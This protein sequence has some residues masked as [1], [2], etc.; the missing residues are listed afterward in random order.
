V[1]LAYIYIDETEKNNF[2]NDYYGGKISLDEYEI[3]LS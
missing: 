2:L 3:A 1:Q